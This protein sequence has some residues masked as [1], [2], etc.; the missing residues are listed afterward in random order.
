MQGLRDPDLL[1]TPHFGVKATVN[2][3]VSQCHQQLILKHGLVSS[4][5]YQQPTAQELGVI[6]SFA[7]NSPYGYLKY[8]AHPHH[9]I[10][11]HHLA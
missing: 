1:L 7:T 9:F 6:D 8:G 4:I 3:K 5:V 10:R 2:L 11:T